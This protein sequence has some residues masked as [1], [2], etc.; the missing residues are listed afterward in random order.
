MSTTDRRAHLRYRDPKTTAQLLLVKDG[1]AEKAITGLIANESHIGLACIYVGSPIEV[2]SEIIWQE[3]QQIQTR[4]KVL[5][6]ERL[7][8]DVFLLAL[9]IVG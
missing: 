2:A 1:E 3:T 4:C 8:M 5:R 6:C 7:Y 9:Q